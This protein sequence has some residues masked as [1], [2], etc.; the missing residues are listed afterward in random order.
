MSIVQDEKP[1]KNRSGLGL[2]NQAPVVDHHQIKLAK[3]LNEL[4][5]GQKISELWSTGN[6]DRTEWL[7]RQQNFLAT[8][9][10][11]IDNE[12]LMRGPWTESSNLHLPV[13]LT[14]V[15]ALHAR[16]F[17]ALFSVQPPFTVRP[18]NEAATVAIP[19]IEGVMQYTIREWLN[20][21]DGVAEVMDQ[22]LWEWITTGT[23]I[24]KLR[25]DRR[26]SR[27]VEA[28]DE[29]VIENVFDD[30]LKRV[31][32]I[33]KTVT[34]EEAVTKK[35]FDGP[36]VDIVSPEDLLILGGDGDT[37]KADT[38]IHRYYHTRSEMYAL[39]DQKVFDPDV[40]EEILEGG[41]D[42]EYTDSAS[43][44]RIDKEANSGII[45]T[46]TAADTDRFEILEAYCKMDVNDDGLDEDVIIWVHSRSKKV[47]R[48]T[49]LY[50]VFGEGY[51]P[52]A[53]IDF[54]KKRGHPYGMG[55]PEIL[56]SL[57]KE[58]DAIHNLKI[59]YGTLSTMPFG[60][61]RAASGMKAETL[62]LEPGKLIPVNDPTTD[63]F[64]PNMGNRTSFADQEEA[65]LLNYVERLVSISDINL[66]VIGGQGAART[67]TGVSA[68]V[69]E[70]NTNLD[71]F[72]KRAQRG[73]RQFL[74]VLL[75][76]LQRR[77]PK[78][79]WIRITGEDGGFHPFLIARGDIQGR[80]DFDIDATS[81]NSNKAVTRE[82]AQQVLNLTMNPLLI[83]MGIVTPDN[84][85]NACKNWV[86]S[87]DVK[88]F[89]RY[90]S[91]PSDLEMFLA[92]S[93]EVARVLQGMPVPVH[94]AM[95][96]QAFMTYVE[97]MMNTPEYLGLLTQEQAIS[98][99]QQYDQHA[100]MQEAV[101]RQEAQMRNLSQQQL[102]AAQ[103]G[104]PQVSV[105]P[106]TPTSGQ[107]R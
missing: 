66:G 50:R 78:E 64:F 42:S 56:Y 70:N 47:L 41:L 46:N 79:M 43:A 8:W 19:L 12:D 2:E 77:M 107:G 18:N 31:V 53:K 84:L 94:P 58:I 6:A 9:D 32:Q 76:V 67:A 45:Q 36:V 101:Q 62:E 85:Y 57:Q 54:L 86:T 20:Y 4:E 30:N 92:P 49:Y 96:H 1:I 81:I 82:I 11:F 74:R 89:A 99:A 3:D 39:A 103:A 75:Q 10:E 90:I 17:A 102:N 25:W 61:Y 38:V 104:A 35:I 83:Q 93:Q 16:M 27:Y 34:K 68:I 73:W 15:R 33:P 29:V 91:K 52:F 95:N 71:I 48:A 5:A 44:L 37:N 26:F 106:A 21:N 63:V 28:R 24:L 7:N 80:F 65:T 69:G 100:A 40:V 14:A 98:V 60:F 22:W 13:T 105:G 59:D 51:R 72:I 55:V 87:L 97:N 23:A 88:D